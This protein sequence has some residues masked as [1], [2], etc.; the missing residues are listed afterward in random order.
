MKHGEMS[1]ADSDQVNKSTGILSFGPLEGRSAETAN[2]ETANAENWHD[3]LHEFPE[4]GPHACPASLGVRP[5]LDT[6]PRIITDFLDLV[7]HWPQMCRPLN[8]VQIIS[9]GQSVS[10]RV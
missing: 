1:S 8:F 10:P 4:D 5:F 2:T 7:H 3:F 6:V 9:W